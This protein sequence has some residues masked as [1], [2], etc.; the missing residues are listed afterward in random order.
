[1]IVAVPKD[2]EAIRRDD[3]ELARRWRRA[4]GEVLPAALER[5]YRIEDMSKDGFYTLRYAL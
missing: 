4:I 1:V 3:P 5:G 2:I